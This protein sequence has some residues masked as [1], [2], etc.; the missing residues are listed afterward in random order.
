M[1]ETEIC[2]SQ[3][4]TGSERRK[5]CFPP[6]FWVDP[7]TNIKALDNFRSTT[8]EHIFNSHRK[9]THPNLPK[10]ERKGIKNVQGNMDIIIKPVDKGGTV[11]IQSRQDY[12]AEC[13]WQ[14]NKDHCRRTGQDMNS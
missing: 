4:T 7:K 5:Q 13:K 14:L 2:T 11:V 10:E 6:T 8:N 3:L 12:D 1:F 9:K